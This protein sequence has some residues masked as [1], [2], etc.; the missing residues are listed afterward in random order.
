MDLPSQTGRQY[1]A[2]VVEVHSGDDLVLMVDLGLDGFYK[3]VRARLHG[4][5]TPDAYKLDSD[6][7]A[8]RVRDKVR[9]M[10]SG[11]RCMIEM[12]AIR[13]G[14]WIVTLYVLKEPEQPLNINETLRSEGY[15]FQG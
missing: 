9:D 8:G 12:H 10:V 6:T 1:Y 13:R 5:D 11:R 7:P 15:I 2:E 3:R 14:G 4:V